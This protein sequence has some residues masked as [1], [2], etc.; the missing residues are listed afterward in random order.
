MRELQV[1]FSVLEL[2]SAALLQLIR[3]CC[4]TPCLSRRAVHKDRTLQDV[5]LQITSSAGGC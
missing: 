5:A 1:L 2:P 3:V 4:W